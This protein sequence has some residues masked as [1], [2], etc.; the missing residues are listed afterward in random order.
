MKLQEKAINF[1]DD[2][3]QV[4]N[5]FAQSKLL[6]FENFLHYRNI[7]IVKNSTE[8]TGRNSFNNFFIRIQEIHQH[9]TRD[10]SN[11]LT[12]IPQSRRS[13]YGTHS[14]RFKSTI[15][16]NTMHMNLDSMTLKH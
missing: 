11:N 12:D 14:I 7:N 9:N 8:K 5:A 4:S 1:K 16:W 15:A 6:R 2:N 13:F 10:T 3:A